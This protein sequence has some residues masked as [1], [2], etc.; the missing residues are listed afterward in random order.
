[1]MVAVDGAPWQPQAT[2]FT[3]VRTEHLPEAR[4]RSACIEQ[5]RDALGRD[6]S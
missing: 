2:P 4:C 1:M 6:D 5:R 3:V